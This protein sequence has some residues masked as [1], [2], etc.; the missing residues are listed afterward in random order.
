[1]LKIAHKN[2]QLNVLSSI[3]T[4]KFLFLREA[5]Q[6]RIFAPPRVLIFMFQFHSI[7][8]DTTFSFVGAYF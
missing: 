6:L 5:L 2:E 3:I 7:V 1:M 4:N 8:F